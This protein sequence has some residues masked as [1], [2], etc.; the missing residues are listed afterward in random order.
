[1]V[2]RMKLVD[3]AVVSDSKGIFPL[4]VADKRFAFKGFFGKGFDFGKDPDE[5]APVGFMQCRKIGFGFFGKI[6][7]VCH[8]ILRRALKSFSDTV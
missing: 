2:C 7:G 4:M 1:M 5:D 6:N 3:Y 8:F